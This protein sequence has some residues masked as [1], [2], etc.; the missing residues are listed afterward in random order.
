[1]RI[2]ISAL[3]GLLASTTFAATLPPPLS[4]AKNALDAPISHSDGSA[5]SVGDKFTKEIDVITAVEGAPGVLSEIGEKAKKVTT[6]HSHF[7]D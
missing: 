1:M 3:A 7:F 6:V 4:A 5:E 2:S